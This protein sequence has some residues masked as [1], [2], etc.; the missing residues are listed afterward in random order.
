M[1]LCLRE[2]CRVGLQCTMIISRLSGPQPEGAV[3]WVSCQL[4]HHVIGKVC[5]VAARSQPPMDGCVVSALSAAMALAVLLLGKAWD[6]AIS[7]AGSAFPPLWSNTS[8]CCVVPPVAVCFLLV[9]A[10]QRNTLQPDSLL[11]ATCALDMESA[12]HVLNRT[13]QSTFH[14]LFLPQPQPDPLHAHCSGMLQNTASLSARA[15]LSSSQSAL[16]T[17]SALAAQL[18]AETR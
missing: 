12:Q 4:R 8:C 14:N 11:A 15:L 5:G 1:L 9:G 6:P 7:P 3:G 18:S 17:A 16:S 13:Q 10:V 2:S